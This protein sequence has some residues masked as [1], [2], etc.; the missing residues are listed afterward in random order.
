MFVRNVSA[1][2]RREYTNFIEVVSA[3]TWRVSPAYGDHDMLPR[4]TRTNSTMPRAMTLAELAQIE[5]AKTDFRTGQTL[6]P[7]ELNAFL[8][9]AA[10]RRAANR[11]L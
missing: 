8:D 2:T 4:M 10:A 5:Q 6:S 7:D 9:A 11:S 3:C 1:L